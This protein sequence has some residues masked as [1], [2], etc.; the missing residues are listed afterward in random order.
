MGVWILVVVALGGLACEKEQPSP[1]RDEQLGIAVTFPGAPEKVRYIEPT[2]FGAMEW[3][4]QAYRPAGRMDTSFQ[5]EVGNLPPGTEGG[6]TPAEVV[7][8]YHRWLLQRFGRVKRE[9][10]PLDK[11][12]GYRYWMV[13]PM[14]THL[15]GVLVVRRGRLHRAEANTSKADDPRAKAFLEG[16]EVLPAGSVQK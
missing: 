4:G 8:T 14:G 5:A 3:F 10:L 7:E 11:G 12:P 6:T 9:A 2:P 15:Q 1:L 16:F 13:S